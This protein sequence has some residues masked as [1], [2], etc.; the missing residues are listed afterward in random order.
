MNVAALDLAGLCC[1]GAAW[2][3]PVIGLAARRGSLGWRS[4]LPAAS[5]LLCALALNLQLLALCARV[6]AGDWSGLEDTCAAV[7][8]AAAVLLA[9][10]ALLDLA[11]LLLCARRP[12][13]TDTAGPDE[14]GH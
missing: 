5:A 11:C 8:A 9:V 1:G 2:L 6:A 4:R 10:T 14:A 3:L 13:P 7:S 12:A